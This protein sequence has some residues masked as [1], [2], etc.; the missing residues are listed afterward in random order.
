[1]PRTLGVVRPNTETNRTLNASNY[2]MG[3]KYVK[4]LCNGIKSAPDHF[5]QVNL[6]YNNLSSRSGEA[7]R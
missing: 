5:D 7:L 3:D 6:R 2:H 4:I 1:M